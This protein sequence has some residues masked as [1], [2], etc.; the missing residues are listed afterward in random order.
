MPVM[1]LS[2]TNDPITI[3]KCLMQDSLPYQ[4]SKTLKMETLLMQWKIQES[5]IRYY[6]NFLQDTYLYD[7]KISSC[8]WE[9]F[10]KISKVQ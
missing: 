6:K 4:I 7:E 3:V 8:H 10:K 1:R 9:D 5:K 2:L